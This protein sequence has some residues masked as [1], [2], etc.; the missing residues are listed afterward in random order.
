M[1][2]THHDAVPGRRSKSGSAVHDALVAG[3]RTVEV[4]DLLAAP[5]LRSIRNLLEVASVSVQSQSASVLVRDRHRGGLRFLVATGTAAHRLLDLQVPENRGIA[6]FVYSSGQPM[7][8]T[9]V[10]QEEHFYDEVDRLTGHKTE[11]LLATPLRVT[12]EVVGVVEFVNR[13]GEPPFLGYTAEEMDLA[14]HF[15]EALAP[16]VEAY[17]MAGWTERLAARILQSASLSEP[18]RQRQEDDLGAWLETLRSS[19]EHQ[20]LLRMAVCLRDITSRGPAERELCLSVLEALQ[21]HTHRRAPRG[22]S[23]GRR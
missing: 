4:V 21:R 1:P 2:G 5:L 8:V 17:E 22:S 3:L 12:E 20:D 16:L 10:S 15:A 6:G 9:D 19:P 14:A 23:R 18:D 7:A 11:T 13:T